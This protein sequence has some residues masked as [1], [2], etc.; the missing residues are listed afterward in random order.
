LPTPQ[1]AQVDEFPA[2]AKAENVPAAQEMQ[3]ALLS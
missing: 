3:V 1:A 2:P